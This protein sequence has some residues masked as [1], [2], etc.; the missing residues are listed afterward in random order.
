MHFDEVVIR[1]V[2]RDEDGSYTERVGRM[3]FVA[4]PLV[5]LDP[6]RVLPHSG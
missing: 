3:A 1:K 4:M 5:G 6:I 2:K